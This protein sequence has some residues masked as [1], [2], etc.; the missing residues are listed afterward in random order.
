M[1][2]SL[3]II[4]VIIIMLGILTGLSV[5]VTAQ[6]IDFA[7]EGANCDLV[8]T[9]GY[10]IAGN[11]TGGLYLDINND[12]YAYFSRKSWGQYAYG[13]EG[14]AWFAS[15]RAYQIT[16]EDSPIFSGSTWYN[17]QYTNYGYS[18]GQTI[19][20]KAL[21]CYSG[22]IAVVE[23]VDGNNVLLSEGGQTYYS[24]SSHGYCVIRY[25][26]VSAVEGSGFLG[27][28]YLGGNPDP[29]PKGHVMSESEGAG[30]TIPDGDYWIG[31]KIAEDFFIDIPGNDYNTYDKQNVQTWR[32]DSGLPPIYDVFHFSYLNN[33]FYK[34]TQLNTNMAID[35][36]GGY[37]ER[38]SNVSMWTYT[39]SVAQQWSIEKTDGGY[40]IRSRGNNYYMD[41]YDGKH[42]NGTNILTWDSHEGN[43][44]FFSF[45]PYTPNEKPVSD[46]K[47]KI[48]SAVS[49]T[50]YLD[51]YGGFDDFKNL[52]NIEVY[53]S[54]DDTFQI[55]YL[56]NGYYRISEET[57]QLALEVIN[58]GE[59][60]Y[61]NNS[62]NIIL[63]GK[64]NRK[65]QAWNIRK[66]DDGT[67]CFINQLSGYYLDLEHANTDNGTNV[68]Q[69]QY[70][71]YNNQKW[72]LHRVIE[73]NMITV[74]NIKSSIDTPEITVEVD[75]N[76]LVA[77]KDYTT[78]FKYDVVTKIYTST[79]NGINNY[80]GSVTKEVA[81]SVVDPTDPPIEQ[82]TILG[83]ADGD[84]VVTVLDATTI[85]KKLASI[86]VPIY[87][88]VAADVDGD[89]VVNVLDATYIQ[90]HLAHMD[91]PFE[92]GKIKE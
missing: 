18:R 64:N 74:G 70:N 14:C 73:D 58:D 25:T 9:G 40:K 13:T 78:S 82:T 29:T 5:S 59:Q 48:S 67:F 41:I 42:E 31:S 2:K 8:E 53:N 54:P 3:S 77:N 60:S 51:V 10:T 92:I 38:G 7:D 28:V 6:E 76:L 91:I 71:G 33:G 35:V 49:S 23:A 46:G 80:C 24:D 85:Q 57:S 63:Y 27:Y 66:N 83:D 79:I 39:G 55:E 21:V 89:K 11:G 52:S 19:R 1:K 68:S 45:I 72:K 37:L 16:G 69:Y 50:C 56:G 65:N 75:G 20:A 12:P 26:T 32:W 15:A 36:Y 34:I 87:I 62:R 22:H 81:I 88:E 4:L 61:L 47:Y 84:G 90:K 86:S 44:Q 17:T 30:R 43:N